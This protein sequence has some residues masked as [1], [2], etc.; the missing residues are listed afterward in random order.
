MVSKI[1]LKSK[2][3]D[4]KEKERECPIIEMRQQ[5][6]Q[7]KK[8]TDGENDSRKRDI[9]ETFFQKKPDTKI[10]NHPWMARAKNQD[11]YIDPHRELAELRAE[12]QKFKTETRK[13]IQELKSLLTSE[14]DYEDIWKLSEE[15][16]QKF[17]NLFHLPPASADSIDEQISKMRGFLKEYSDDDCDPVD[18]IHTMRN[19]D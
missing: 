13:E 15:N 1:S 17:E 18:L 8:D 4:R 19:H 11:G 9:F 3:W 14:Q 12:F 7:T 5:Y 10:L 16:I 2:E 6:Q